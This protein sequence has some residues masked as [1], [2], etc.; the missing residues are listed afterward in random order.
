MLCNLMSAG[1]HLDNYEGK[2]DDNIQASLLPYHDLGEQELISA[3]LWR[4]LNATEA[5]SNLYQFNRMESLWSLHEIFS[6]YQLKILKKRMD[7]AL[8]DLTS[9]KS[10]AKSRRESERPFFLKLLCCV[11]C[12]RSKDDEM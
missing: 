3:D 10:S 7:I 4:H 6:Q 11:Y 12:S 8:V 5:G 2:A 1:H 9:A